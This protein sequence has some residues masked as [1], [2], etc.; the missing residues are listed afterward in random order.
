[1]SSPCPFD[2]HLRRKT[3]QQRESVTGGLDTRR[4]GALLLHPHP[5]QAQPP[6]GSLFGPGPFVVTAGWCCHCA[7]VWCRTPQRRSANEP[8]T[9][10]LLQQPSQAILSPVPTAKGDIPTATSTRHTTATLQDNLPQILIQG[11][12]TLQGVLSAQ[13]IVWTAQGNFSGTD[14]NCPGDQPPCT[15]VPFADLA[16]SQVEIT[17]EQV[18]V[19]LNLPASG[20]VSFD[21]Q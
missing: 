12:L 13:D 8:K 11:T 16:P 14:H 7:A 10:N 6:K 18:R 15:A 17:A 19:T 9:A 3:K 5:R 2:A 20:P 21:V 1:M 4:V